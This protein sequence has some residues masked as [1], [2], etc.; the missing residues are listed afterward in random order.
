M[1]IRMK[2]VLSSEKGSNVNTDDITESVIKIIRN[3]NNN[4]SVEINEKSRIDEL[5]VDSINYIRLIVGFE[6]RFEVEFEES[7]LRVTAFETI[8][9]I[10]E[11][12]RELIRR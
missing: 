3:I 8:G 10:T 5:G 4:D 6:D 7:K 1:E 9:E 12:I 11:Y 2:E